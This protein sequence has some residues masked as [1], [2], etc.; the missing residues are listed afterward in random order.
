MWLLFN[1]VYSVNAIRADALRLYCSIVLNRVLG[2]FVHALIL[3]APLG[4]LT[5]PP[6]RLRRLPVWQPVINGYPAY[7]EQLQGV[8]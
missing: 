2:L 3:Y 1:N 4:V 6:E 8:R 7:T 5:H